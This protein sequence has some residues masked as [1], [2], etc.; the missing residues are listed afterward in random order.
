[1]VVM[2]HYYLCCSGEDDNQ[3]KI[4]PNTENQNLPN[5]SRSLEQYDVLKYLNS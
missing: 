2:N 1:M 3:S 4:R 5:K